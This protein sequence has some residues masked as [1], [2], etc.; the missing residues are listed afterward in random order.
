MVRCYFGNNN[1]LSEKWMVRV[2]NFGQD[3]PTD[4]PQVIYKM[5]I[6]ANDLNEWS[7]IVMLE[8][9]NDAQLFPDDWGTLGQFLQTNDGIDFTTL[10][11]TDAIMAYQFAVDFAHDILLDVE[12]RY[13]LPFDQKPVYQLNTVEAIEIKEHTLLIQ[14]KAFILETN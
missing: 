2:M 3:R 14:G 4:V 13:G 8:I 12:Q 5:K 10:L 1:E 9:K 6:N 7:K 11:Q